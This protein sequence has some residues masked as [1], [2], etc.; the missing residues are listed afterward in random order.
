MCRSQAGYSGGCGEGLFQ[1]GL[2]LVEKAVDF[3]MQRLFLST[4]PFSKRWTPPCKLSVIQRPDDGASARRPQVECKIFS[5]RHVPSP[6]FAPAKLRDNTAK[7]LFKGFPPKLRGR[8]MYAVLLR[9]WGS[10]SPRAPPQSSSVGESSHGTSSF[11]FVS[12]SPRLS[13]SS[14]RNLVEKAFDRFALPLQ[15][16][17]RHMTERR[18]KYCPSSDLR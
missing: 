16:R 12:G 15:C 17:T 18:R 1:S 13:N 11:S 6:K 5:L 14:S 2:Q 7:A 8:T 10:S 3:P 4:G 9:P